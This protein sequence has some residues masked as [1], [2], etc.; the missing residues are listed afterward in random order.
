MPVA[1]VG[2]QRLIDQRNLSALP[3]SQ[4]ARIDTRVKGRETQADGTGTQLLFE[5]RY[6]PEASFEGDLQFAFRYEGVNLEALELLF[7][8]SGPEP[9]VTWLRAQPESSYA[10]RAGFLYEW[11]T[12]KELDVPQLS[13]RTAYVS[14][15]DESLQFGMGDAGR[16]DRKFRVR[17]NLPGTRE[18]CPLIRK[19]PAILEMTQKNLHARAQEMLARYEPG[20]L[21]R[22]AQCLM[23]K[24]TRSSYEVEREKPSQNRIQ[25]FVD[26][27]RSAQTGQPL[28]Q[29]RFVALQNAVLEPR[30]HEFSYRHQQNWVGSYH[31]NRDVVDFVPRGQKMS[32]H[33]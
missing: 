2:Y 12:G 31:G 22:A 15:L 11:I 19:T 1:T 14:A 9:L 3:L 4:V 6:Q 29:E 16:L 32:S 24:E 21:R 5:P 28:S 17:D 8:Q 7:A 10:R 20:L 23:L 33:C 26:L 25:R 13:T 18:F 27:L 30:W